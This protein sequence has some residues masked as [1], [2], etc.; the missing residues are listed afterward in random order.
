M[1]LPESRRLE[2]TWCVWNVSVIWITLDRD[3]DHVWLHLGRAAVEGAAEAFLP[4]SAPLRRLVTFYHKVTLR[5]WGSLPTSGPDE[6]TLQPTAGSAARDGFGQKNQSSA[7]FPTTEQ[8]VSLSMCSTCSKRRRN[9]YVCGGTPTDWWNA[10]AKWSVESPARAANPSSRIFS[11]RC[12]SIWSQTRR[13]M[14]GDNPPRLGVGIVSADKFS[15]VLSRGREWI[16]AYSELCSSLDVRRGG[17]SKRFQT[18][19]LKTRCVEK[20]SLPANAP[21]GSSEV[22]EEQLPDL[23]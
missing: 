15:S 23:A 13:V 12:P 19:P 1:V 10:R 5:E 18:R 14:A 2:Q 3:T 11:S 6:E 4:W 17:V 16:M 20:F 22:R 21:I 9:R 7:L 8:C